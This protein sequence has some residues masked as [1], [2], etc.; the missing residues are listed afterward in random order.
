[1]KL[2]KLIE[3][4]NAIHCKEGNIEVLIQ[5]GCIE[6]IDVVYVDNGYEEDK[7]VAIISAR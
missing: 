3:S 5:F 4:L 1:M 6:E 7:A 2:L